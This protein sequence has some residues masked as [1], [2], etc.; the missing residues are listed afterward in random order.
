MDLGGE[1][2][3]PAGLTTLEL[4]CCTWHYTFRLVHGDAGG[5][6]QHGIG[7]G[8]SSDQGGRAGVSDEPSSH[9]HPQL[10][11]TISEQHNRMYTVMPVPATVTELTL[12][13]D[14]HSFSYDHTWPPNLV[15]LDMLRADNYSLPS[16]QLPPTLQVRDGATASKYVICDKQSTSRAVGDPAPHPAA[17]RSSQRLQR[18]GVH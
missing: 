7:G 9:H 8:L 13:G 14:F 6:V 16:G 15:S 1:L 5:E 18:C 12:S 4:E 10:H 3:L 17:A 11:L 2:L